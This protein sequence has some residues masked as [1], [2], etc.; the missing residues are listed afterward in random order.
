MVRKYDDINSKANIIPKLHH[1]INIMTYLLSKASIFT[2]SGVNKV[3]LIV[4]VKEQ[5]LNFSPK[6]QQI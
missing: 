4:L 2:V 3:T 6:E 5:T 1:D